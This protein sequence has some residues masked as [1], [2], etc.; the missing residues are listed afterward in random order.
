[1]LRYG[2]F[3]AFKS[4]PKLL[5]WGEV[6]DMARLFEAL[7]QM[8]AGEGPAALTDIA[9]CLSADG[10]TVLLETVGEAAGIE[11]DEDEPDVFHWRV[12]EE[13]WYAFQEQVETLTR[14]TAAKP[15]H[16]HLQ[17]LADGEIAVMVSCGEYPADLRPD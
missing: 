6:A 14:C 3:H 17:C 4:G 5:I 13:G 12:D 8:A 7:S 9:D 2:Y 16:Q 10:S 15:G 11:R 1:M